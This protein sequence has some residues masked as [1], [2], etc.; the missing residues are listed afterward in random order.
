[1]RVLQIHKSA[2][3]KG[4]D[5]TYVQ[6]LARLLPDYGVENQFLYANNVGGKLHLEINGKCLKIHLSRLH[7][8]LAK[9]LDENAIDLINIQTNLFTPLSRACVDLRPT[10]KTTHSTDFVCPGRLRFASAIDK[11]CERRYSAACYLRGWRD[12][13]C[14]RNPG[15]FLSIFN[16][17]RQENGSLAKRYRKI[18]VMSNYIRDQHIAAGVEV[19]KLSVIPYFVFPPAAKPADP[20][21]RAELKI[22]YSGRLV[23]QKGVHLMLEAM[24][25]ILKEFQQISLDVVGDDVDRKH[26]EAMVPHE[27]RA[28]VTFPGW[29]DAEGVQRFLTRADLVL[30]P[31]IYPE[32]FGISGIEAMAKGKPVIAFDVGGVSEW[33]DHEVT[34]LLVEAGNVKRYEEAIRRLITDDSTRE[35]MSR[36]ASA[37]VQRFFPEHHLSRL[38]Q[39]YEEALSAN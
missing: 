34:G 14:T 17:I 15:S 28:Q 39:V 19:G 8:T 16:S 23:R 25:P 6:N 33:L 10:I 3:I 2:V 36:E 21:K 1:M 4:G 31:S 5:D 13:C 35:R 29:Q 30:F 18:V 9:E 24:M 7:E 38:V 32:A 12:R 37:R 11:G 22:V 20:A 27:L 26:F